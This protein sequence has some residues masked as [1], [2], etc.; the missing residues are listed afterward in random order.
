VDWE[1]EPYGDTSELV[2]GVAGIGVVVGEEIIGSGVEVL[3]RG[4]GKQPGEA[5]YNFYR[6]RLRQ[7]ALDGCR[8]ESRLLL[9]IVHG[10]DNWP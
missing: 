9:P 10:S 2:N 7:T 6:Q 8:G 5:L 3:C 4:I 1:G